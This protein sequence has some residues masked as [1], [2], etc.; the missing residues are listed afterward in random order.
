VQKKNKI[1]LGRWHS[2][3]KMREAGMFHQAIIMDF[4]IAVLAKRG[5]LGLED[6]EA[7]MLGQRILDACNSPHNHAYCDW[8]D[9][10]AQKPLEGNEAW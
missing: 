2:N 4:A 5:I 1:P 8:A 7:N 10:W 6:D 3:H 9:T